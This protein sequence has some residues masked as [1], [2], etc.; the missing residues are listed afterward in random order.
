MYV[1][2]GQEHLRGRTLNFGIWRFLSGGLVVKGTSLS[3]KLESFWGC[4]RCV[5]SKKTYKI[6]KRGEGGQ[7]FSV[8]DF[9]T[10]VATH[11]VPWVS[12]SG[13][14]T[15]V[16]S[17][18]SPILIDLSG[19]IL[20]LALRFRYFCCF[21]CFYWQKHNICLAPWASSSRSRHS[22]WNMHDNL[23]WVMSKEPAS[24]SPHPAATQLFIYY[25]WLPVPAASAAH[26]PH[27]AAS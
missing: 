6:P 10:S 5:W 19:S 23:A 17:F 4:G 25:T 11:R 26:V 21:I 20:H 27:V 1:W 16:Y 9:Q 15:R 18:W 14:N 2:K 22:R 24:T 13:E 8:F 12:V 3:V 7:K